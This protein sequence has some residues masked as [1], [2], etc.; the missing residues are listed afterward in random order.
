MVF[1]SIIGAICALL[2]VS[3]NANA[4]A[5]LESRLGGLAYYDPVADLTWLA[6]ANAL[7]GSS[8]DINV[9]GTGQSTWA[10]ANAWV[11]SLDIA[12]VTGWRLPV[13]I[14]VGNDGPTYTNIFQGVDYGY[15]ITTPS[16]MSNLYYNVLG[17]TAYWDINGVPVGCTGPNICLTNS[18]PFSNIQ[19]YYYSTTEFPPD[20]NSVWAFD[21]RYGGQFDY[22]KGCCSFAWAL[23]DG[24]VEPESVPGP[25]IA[26]LIA[27]GLFGLIWKAKTKSV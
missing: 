25:P 24:D 16:E 14:D 11:A 4:I 8:Y 20:T 5:I 21:M 17:N 22:T 27:T 15:N 6:D 23:H 13:T 2:V 10:T 9:Y 26:L 1:K 12:G 3:F 18:G 7:A 19:S